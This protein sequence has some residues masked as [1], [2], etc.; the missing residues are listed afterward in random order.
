MTLLKL[1]CGVHALQTLLGKLKP[2]RT[3]TDDQGESANLAPKILL[4]SGVAV[5]LAILI[6]LGIQGAR[7]LFRRGSGPPRPPVG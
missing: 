1:L 4:L 3:A 6:G 2:E 7:A 5:H